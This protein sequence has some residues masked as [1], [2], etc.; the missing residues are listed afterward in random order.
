MNVLALDSFGKH[1]RGAILK[2]IFCGTAV[3]ARVTRILL[4]ILPQRSC[5][6]TCRFSVA[7]GKLRLVRIGLRG[8]EVMLNMAYEAEHRRPAPDPT[9][10]ALH[11]D[12]CLFFGCTDL[13][14][15]YR[16]PHAHAIDVK[17]PKV[18]PYGIRPLCSRIPTDMASA[19]DIQPCRNGPDE[20][21]ERVQDRTEGSFLAGGST[22]ARARA[23]S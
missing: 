20:G 10:M 2:H 21:D 18:V 1:F 8:A 4:R 11:E 12:P 14:A 9:R 16:H 7:W 13:D 5:P 15:T 3:S 6:A 23:S 22:S 17:K 19:S